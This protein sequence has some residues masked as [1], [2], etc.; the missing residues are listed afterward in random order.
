MRA[1]KR[2]RDLLY[3]PLRLP[4]GIYIDRNTAYDEVR[5]VFYEMV[6]I[7][8]HGFMLTVACHINSLRRW[9]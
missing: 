2:E 7:R 3:T 4:T 6:I 5:R 9:W 8:L 1:F